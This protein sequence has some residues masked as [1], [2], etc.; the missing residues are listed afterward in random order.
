MQQWVKPVFVIPTSQIRETVIPLTQLADVPEKAV[1]YGTV[2][3]ALPPT[4]LGFGMAQHRLV[5]AFESS[6][7]S[8]G[9]SSK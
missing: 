4:A 1:A 5:Q 7:P 3:G 8:L 9:H 6:S 2:L